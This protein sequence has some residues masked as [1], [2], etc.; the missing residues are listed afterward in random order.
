[1]RLGDKNAAPEKRDEIREV[2]L[3]CCQGMHPL[4]AGSMFLPILLEADVKVRFRTSRVFQGCLQY[5]QGRVE[6]SKTPKAQN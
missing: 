2:L 6:V 5:S 1:M 4:Q 3:R